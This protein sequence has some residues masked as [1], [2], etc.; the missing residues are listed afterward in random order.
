MSL[1]R[2]WPLFGLCIE[3]PQLTLRYATDDDLATL[4]NLAGQGIHDPAV[5]PF[6]VPWTDDP[7]EIRPQH[8]L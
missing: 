8:S 1:D 6:D 7:P 2:D 5:M 4:N 3:T